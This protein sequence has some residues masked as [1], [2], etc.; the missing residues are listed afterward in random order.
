MSLEELHIWIPMESP[1]PI[2]D[3]TEKA[4]GIHLLESCCEENP[5]VPRM[6]PREIMGLSW[7]KEHEVEVMGKDMREGI[8]D[9]RVGV[10]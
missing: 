7:I 2:I 9:G 8:V 10:G 5:W 6:G 4:E 3:T 1:N